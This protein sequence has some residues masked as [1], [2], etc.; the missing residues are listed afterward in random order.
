MVARGSPT[1][2]E[3]QELQ[4]RKVCFGRESSIDSTTTSTPSHNLLLLSCNPLFDAY[5]IMEIDQVLDHVPSLDEKLNYF[6]KCSPEDISGLVTL[7][8]SEDRLPLQ[9]LK[10][11]SREKKL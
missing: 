11:I 6:R 8:I 4:N 5:I 1:I 7:V 10:V 3:K 9:N 2:C